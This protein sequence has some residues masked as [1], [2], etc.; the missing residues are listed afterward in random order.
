LADKA[1]TGFPISVSFAA[2]ELA[3]PKK[4]DGFAKQTQNGQLN[5]E[6]MTGDI[7]NQGGD[8]FLSSLNLDTT[9]LM[10]PN[11]ARFV[12]Q[13]QFVNPIL[14]DLPD[15]NIYSH[16]FTAE[17]TNKFEIS[18]EVLPAVGSTYTWFGTGTPAAVPETAQSSV[19]A[20]GDWYIDE[21]TGRCFFADA[22][23]VDWELIYEPDVQGTDHGDG[24]CNVIPDPFTDTSYGFLGCKLAYANNVDDTQG[25]IVFLPPRGPLDSTKRP[26]RYPQS[27]Y[28]TSLNEG[29][30]AIDPTL[31]DVYVWQHHDD[32]GTP[33]DADTSVNAEHYRYKMPSILTDNWTQASVLPPGMIYLWDHAVT[34]T[35]IEGLVYTAED[36]ATPRQYVVIASGT[37]LENWIGTHMDTAYS[38]VGGVAALTQ[39]DNHDPSYYP[40]SGL[41]VVT[42]GQSLSQL[43]HQIRDMVLDHQHT[44]NSPQHVSHDQIMNSFSPDQ[45]PGGPLIPASSLD[46]D[47]HANY[48]HRRGVQGNTRDIYNNGMLGNLFMCSV[49]S[50]ANYQN[51]VGNSRSIR[52]GTAAGPGLRY[53]VGS[54]L[55][56]VIYRGLGIDNELGDTFSAVLDGAGDTIL[57]CTQNM[58]LNPNTSIIGFGPTGNGNF[59]NFAADS[60]LF[61]SAGSLYNSAS[62]TSFPG[63]ISATSTSFPSLEGN[64]AA[65]GARIVGG[66]SDGEFS[67]EDPNETLGSKK[68]GTLNCN[69]YEN[70]EHNDSHY[71]YLTSGGGYGPVRKLVLSPSDFVR[72]MIKEDDTP[73]DFARAEMTVNQTSNLGTNDHVEFDFIDTSPSSSITM[74]TG[75]G[76]DD[77]KITLPIGKY[78]EITAV[79][80]GA[81]NSN[82]GLS[83]LQLYNNTDSTF[84]GQELMIDGPQRAANWNAPPVMTWLF[85]TIDEAKEIELRISETSA[86]PNHLVTIYERTTS[87]Y[88][89]EIRNPDEAP[90]VI[91]AR[92]SS[93]ALLGGTVI[94]DDIDGVAAYPNLPFMKWG[95]VNLHMYMRPLHG[96][97]AALDATATLGTIY[98]LGV[99][100]QT[101]SKD[102]RTP[103]GALAQDTW[104]STTSSTRIFD[105]DTVA[106]LVEIDNSETGSHSAIPYFHIECASGKEVEFAHVIMLYRVKEF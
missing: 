34:E 58:V 72:P 32:A 18:L 20:S 100:H 103:F 11:L 68:G 77:G 64:T 81:H 41:R 91:G 33:V 74:S 88:I 28:D 26:A 102:L 14:P 31:P 35:I 3:D 47:P 42:A 62:V 36:V 104:S 1:R 94:C 65:A 95:I 76:Q 38:G 21:V 82:T 79:G 73:V 45:V 85:D 54:D 49:D 37:A 98:D 4:F 6:Y 71:S 61:Y 99:D 84:H 52:F 7:W 22:I 46:N 8:L 93:Y 69:K 17:E 96:T 2:G 16:S 23:G 97:L 5:L 67:V 90:N 101:A 63:S 30:F 43:A 105:I 75:A 78:W 66:H 80:H 59:L 9:A 44:N 24:T 50:T 39:R 56:A 55:L 57:G 15:A 12:G 51:L 25:Y 10:I 89:K 53:D 83:Y 87:L 60:F 70:G 86:N 29:N 48:L 19:T 92:G 40:G 27:P 106:P 13:S